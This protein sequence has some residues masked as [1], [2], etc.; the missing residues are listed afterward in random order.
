[1][2]P[3]LHPCLSGVILPG[4]WRAEVIDN[5]DGDTK[6]PH[7]GRI[8]VR[9]P[10]LHGPNDAENGVEDKDLPWAVPSFS[11]GG[12]I[13]K[14]NDNYIRHGLVTIPPV[15][16][17][18]WV[19]FEGGNPDRPFWSGTWYGERDTKDIGGGSEIPEEAERDSSVGVSYPNIWLLKFPWDEDGIWLRCSEDKK[20]EI[21]FAGENSITLKKVGDDAGKIV[22]ETKKPDWDVDVLAQHG[23][24]TLRASDS[25]KSIMIQSAGSITM[26]AGT[27]IDVISAGTARFKAN[28]VNSFES[29]QLIQ[30]VAPAAVGFA[31]PIPGNVPHFHR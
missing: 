19:Q 11:M 6:H 3:F 4:V 12:G 22:I 23:N 18:V 20:F 9:I 30:G 14:D 5:D 2:E 16:S 27:H 21:V 8:Q 26:Q 13:V 10:Q 24:I 31:D 28:G 25:S 29:N 1:M 17:T 7:L 15:G